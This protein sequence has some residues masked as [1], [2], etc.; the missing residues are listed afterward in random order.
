MDLLPALPAPWSDGEIKGLKAR[1]NY[2]VDITWKKGK[3]K[4]ASIT[5]L[6]RG[7][8]AINYNNKTKNITF[9][10]GGNIVLK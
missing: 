2:S 10:K 4:K 3:V 6:E 5:S 8:L 9:K 7:T 1:G